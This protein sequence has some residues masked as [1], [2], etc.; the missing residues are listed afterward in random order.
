MARLVSPSYGVRYAVSAED[1]Q[2]N[3][4]RPLRACG[5]HVLFSW[6]ERAGFE[7]LSKSVKELV[8]WSG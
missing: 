3:Q 6:G 4:F 8:L 1:L 5:P 7:E 2:Y